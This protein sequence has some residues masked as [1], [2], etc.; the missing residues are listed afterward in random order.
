M[1]SMPTDANT[2][3]DGSNENDPRTVERLTLSVEQVALLKDEDGIQIVDLRV[4][5]FR[6]CCLH[7]DSNKCVAF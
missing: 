7:H 4:S 1:P 2:G 3:S 5:Y 6:I